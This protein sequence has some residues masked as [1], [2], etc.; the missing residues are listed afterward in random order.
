MPDNGN[1]INGYRNT[2]HI[3]AVDACTSDC[4]QQSPQVGVTG[5]K[6]RFDQW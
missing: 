5:K 6:G 3:E 1:V 2:C 4:H